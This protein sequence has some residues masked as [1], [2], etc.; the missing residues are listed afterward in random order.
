MIW[1]WKRRAADAASS[2]ER[3]ASAAE[4]N[5]ESAARLAEAHQLAAE[6]R[7][8]TAAK[9]RELDKNRWTELFAEALARRA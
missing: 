5:S 2:K 9:R 4:K 6:H 7:V 8:V 1:P 3:E